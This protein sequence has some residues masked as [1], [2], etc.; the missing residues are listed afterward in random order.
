MEPLNT[1]GILKMIY[2]HYLYYLKNNN[3][4]GKAT[5]FDMNEFKILKTVYSQTTGGL[6][7]HEGAIKQQKDTDK[8]WNHKREAGWG[9]G[10]VSLV[11]N[12]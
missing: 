11:L 9:E 6:R 10:D 4:K 7:N 8:K 5:G 2:T 12:P 1:V 3:E